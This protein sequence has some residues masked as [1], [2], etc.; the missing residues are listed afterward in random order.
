MQSETTDFA[1]VPP[2]A[3]VVET[4]ASPL[5]LAHSL[6]YVKL[7]SSTKPDIHNVLHR[8]QRMTEPRP[9][10]TKMYRHFGVLWTCGF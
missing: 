6:Y 8:H 4:Y 7:M 2:L 3:E 5:I 10:M 9:Q 1:P